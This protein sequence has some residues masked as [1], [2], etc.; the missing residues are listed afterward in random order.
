LVPSYDEVLSYMRA[1]RRNKP[2][3]LEVGVLENVDGEPQWHPPVDWDAIPI[4]RHPCPHCGRRL[5]TANG[6]T[7]HIA[8]KHDATS[9]GE[10]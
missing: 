2:G 5:K 1:V 4:P 6:L 3:F 9:R 10:R 8:A 7:Q